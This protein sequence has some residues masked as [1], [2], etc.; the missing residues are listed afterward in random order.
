[1]HM[2]RGIAYQLYCYNMVYNN[3]VSEYI[4]ISSYIR[5]DGASNRTDNHKGG[6]CNRSTT[7]REEVV[8]G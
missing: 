7:K 8:A 6:E 2:Y 4:I 5:C 3:I 1:M